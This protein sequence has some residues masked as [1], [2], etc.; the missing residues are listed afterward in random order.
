MKKP[1]V[2]GFYGE[3]NTGKTTVIARI[4][5]K[6]TE[7]N[8]SVASIK[9]TD[10]KITIDQKGK[11]TWKHAKAGAKL[12]ILKTECETDYLFKKKQSTKEIIQN[13]SNYDSYDIILI[14]GANDKETLKIRF[15]DIKERKNTIYT[16]DNDF[17]KLYNLIKGMIKNG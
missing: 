5:K 4:I 3:S 16:Y 7:E 11:D 1:L 9:N 2:V 6:L 14:E 15:G 12:V 10:K 13:I 8:F 17:Q